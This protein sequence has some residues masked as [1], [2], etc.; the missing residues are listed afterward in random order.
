MVEIPIR[1]YHFTPVK[2]VMRGDNWIN[3]KGSILVRSVGPG[4]SLVSTVYL[5]GLILLSPVGSDA[6]RLVCEHYFPCCYNRICQRDRRAGEHSLCV[7]RHSQGT[8]NWTTHT[9][10]HTCTHTHAQRMVKESLVK[11]FMC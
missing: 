9:H 11:N 3:L 10:A 8:V 4:Y 1:C 7:H 2:P 5:C 6:G